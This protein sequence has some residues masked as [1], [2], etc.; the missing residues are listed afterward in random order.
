MRSKNIKLYQPSLAAR[1][2]AKSPP[3]YLAKITE[4]IKAGIGFPAIHFD[5]I[6]IKMLL[7]LGVG[8]EDARDYCIAGCVEPS[9]SGLFYRF[10]S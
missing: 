10:I 1:V 9:V 3:E 4:V 2:H 8:L 5:D 7:S 6:T